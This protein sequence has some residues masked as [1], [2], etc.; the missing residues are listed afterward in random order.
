MRVDFESRQ[1]GDLGREEFPVLRLAPDA[2]ASADELQAAVS[3]LYRHARAGRKVV[4]LVPLARGATPAPLVE[5][6]DAV[7]L[8]TAF[9][10]HA[11]ETRAY[12]DGAKGRFC[13]VALAPASADP[14]DDD[15][16]ES[17]PTRPL[18]VA[19]AGLGLIGGGAARRLVGDRAYHLC[20][21]F[22]R[23]PFKDRSA[24]TIGQV[25]NDLT[26][27]FATKPQIIVE[28]LSDGATGRRVI[29]AALGRG[30]GVVTANKQAIAG[31]LL[32]LTALAECSGAPFAYS[33]T[34][35][36]GAP[37][38]ETAARVRTRGPVASIEA[39]LNGTVNFVLTSLSQGVPFEAAVRAAQE[40]GFAE[41][42][43]SA[44][45]S[46]VDAR[47]KLSILS[48]AAFGREI[49]LEEIEI[50]ALTT[51]RA[52]AIGAEGGSWKQIARLIRADGGSVKASLRFERRDDDPF[53]VSAV[54]ESNAMR[55]K[56]ANGAVVE[57]RGKGAGLKPTVESILADLD[58]VAVRLGEAPPPP[59]VASA[60]AAA[61]LIA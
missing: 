54:R 18:R 24:L 32:D 38:L 61:S 6:L 40:A 34:V 37:L 57:R 14:E 44:D 47:A 46:G 26:A 60:T 36:G 22:V 51:E 45:L 42:D 33:A 48:F 52:A 16:D 29:E 35:G 27:L 39:V 4:A 15:G 9:L 49:P 25:T 56:L 7:G 58:D 10:N 13:D 5:A 3:T 19:S 11:D 1:G 8:E 55:I 59:G 21:A 41:P 53:F 12:T 20:G 30:I 2:L 43:P 23:E 50:E 28:A 31:A 17:S